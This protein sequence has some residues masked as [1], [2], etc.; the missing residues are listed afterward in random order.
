MHAL[1]AFLQVQSRRKE[2]GLRR[3]RPAS[4]S[5]SSGTP[6]RARRR[7]APPGADVPRD[8]L[9][10][11]RA[12][13]S[14]S[15]AR[16]SSASGSA[17]PPSRP[18]GSIRRALDGVLF[19]DEAYALDPR[20][21]RRMDFG[22]GGGRDAAQAHGGLPPPARRDRRPVTRCSCT[23]SS[24][25][26]RSPVALRA[27]DRLSR[28]TRPTNWSRSRTLCGRAR[29]PAHRG[30]R[31]ELRAVF[32]RCQAERGLRERS[33]LT[34]GLRAGAERP[35]PSARPGATSRRRLG[36][37][38]NAH[39]RGHRGGRAFARGRG[40]GSRPR[41]L[42]L[43]ALKLERFP[44]APLD[45]ELQVEGHEPAPSGRPIPAE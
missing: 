18:T 33:L 21:K 42:P 28:T 23:D 22:P 29:I 40:T 38:P 8:G 5:S 35:R 25:R 4:T 13:W 11:P 2:H 12:T 36:R 31:A 45:P 19:I 26:I 43:Q 17:R 32:E 37:P 39:S 3:P 15:I 10:P 30:R 27:R 20:G 7:R 34:D 6:G 16:G 44:A 1:V 24:D 14:R 41:T 9:A